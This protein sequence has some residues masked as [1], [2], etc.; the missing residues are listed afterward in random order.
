MPLKFYA[1]HSFEWMQ[2]F[3][4][5]IPTN[6][7]YHKS[8]AYC[9]ACCLHHYYIY[10]KQP[11]FKLTHK[12]LELFAINRRSLRRY[13]ELFK[14]TK[15]LQYTI[16][17]NKT[18]IVTLLLLPTTNYKQTTN[19]T[20]IPIRLYNN[21]QDTLH[22]CTGY[23]YKNVQDEKR[24]KE[25][26]NPATQQ[27]RNPATKEPTKEGRNPLTNSDMEDKTHV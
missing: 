17:D 27:P 26:S 15:L 2:H 16:E 1:G 13:L 9:I 3:F 25:P 5:A 20:N 4:N 14:Q 22:K 23:L 21:V 19:N 7:K 8:I 10:K 24:T 11:T 12:K 18:P 6:K